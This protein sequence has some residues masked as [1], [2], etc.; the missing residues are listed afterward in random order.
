VGTPEQPVSL[1]GGLQRSPA[2]TYAS[3]PFGLPRSEEFAMSETSTLPWAVRTVLIAVSE[4]DRSIPFYRDIGPFPEI[5][6]EGAVAVLGE[7]TPTSI[8]LLLREGSTSGYIRH[9]QQSLGLRSMCL[10]VP[11]APELDRIEGV[12]R[13]R[14]LFTARQGDAGQSSDLVLGRDPD[15]LPLVFVCYADGAE[16]NVDYYRNIVNLVYSLDT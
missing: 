5:V 3:S 16:T 6:R 9:G 14:G 12:L 2:T 4:L 7:M 10:T 11:S 8:I 15:N 13:E 1:V